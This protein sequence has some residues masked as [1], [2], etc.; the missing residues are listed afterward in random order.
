MNFY[1]E[2]IIR[3]IKII[4]IGWATVMYFILALIILHILNNIY[5]KPDAKYYEKMDT[6]NITIEF[7]AY[8]WLIG[9]II[10]IIRNIFPLFPFLFDGIFGYD[11]N[12]V[13]EVTGATAFS[14]FIITFNDR[15]Q[16]YYLILKDRLFGFN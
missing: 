8:I 16:N 1:K 14:I 7:L 3:S 12:K 13:K 15:L 11:H 6:F 9:V 5:G 2:F 4:N 10:Y